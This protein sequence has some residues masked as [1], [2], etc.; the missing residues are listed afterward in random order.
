MSLKAAL[1]WEAETG[2]WLNG[3]KRLA[4]EAREAQAALWMRA[5]SNK[6]AEGRRRKSSLIRRHFGSRSRSHEA[7]RQSPALQVFQ[8]SLLVSRGLAARLFSKGLECVLEL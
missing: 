5:G 7:V 1:C 6:T 2:L 4:R 3:C 8:C